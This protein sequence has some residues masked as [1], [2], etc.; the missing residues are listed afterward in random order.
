MSNRKILSVEK[1]ADA[2]RMDNTP[3]TSKTLVYVDHCGIDHHQCYWQEKPCRQ[4]KEAV[5]LRGG[6]LCYWP[7]TARRVLMHL[8][9]FEAVPHGWRQCRHKP[10]V[11]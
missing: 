5:A 8:V 2:L 1:L 4:R 6:S 10:A 3:V 11:V 9:V 7:L